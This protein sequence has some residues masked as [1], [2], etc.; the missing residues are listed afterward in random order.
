MDLEMLSSKIKEA[1]ECFINGVN[2]AGNSIL[3]GCNLEILVEIEKQ[4][5]GINKLKEC[6]NEVSI[7]PRQFYSTTKHHE[8][9]VKTGLQQDRDYIRHLEAALKLVCAKIAEMDNA[10]PNEYCEPA[11]AT[12]PTQD[13]LFEHY[14][15][16]DHDEVIE[17]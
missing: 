14:L 8:F 12:K 3:I 17:C 4:K 11:Y 15:Y 1:Q 10:D 9:A 6:Q 7:M 5:A 13:N 2:Y 16:A